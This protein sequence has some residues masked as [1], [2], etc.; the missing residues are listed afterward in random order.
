M[1]ADIKEYIISITSLDRVGIIHNVVSV[2][3]SMDGNLADIQ[4]QVL[5]GYF[6]MILYVAFPRDI[7]RQLIRISRLSKTCSSHADYF[8]KFF[9]WVTIME[10]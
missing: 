5:R 3:S 6:S 2:I 8:K 7:P 9:I 1:K 4:Q 10:G